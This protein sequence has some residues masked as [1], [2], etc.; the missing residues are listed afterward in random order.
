M[1]A[2]QASSKIYKIFRKV[3]QNS[4]EEE[5]MRSRK[6]GGFKKLSDLYLMEHA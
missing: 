3:P 1:L 4:A 2:I 5:Q 6:I